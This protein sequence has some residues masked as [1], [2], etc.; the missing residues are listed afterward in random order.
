M[1]HLLL[2][3]STATPI[4]RLLSTPH[5]HRQAWFYHVMLTDGDPPHDQLKMLDWLG[6]GRTGTGKDAFSKTFDNALHLPP[7][8]SNHFVSITSVPAYGSPTSHPTSYHP[9]HPS[10]APRIN[11]VRSSGG[12][13]FDGCLEM[14]A[15]Y[16]ICADDPPA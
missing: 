1:C 16:G 3:L 12:R 9:L 2:S 11:Y 7:F 5:R 15:E 10:Y 8:P 13:V 4:L 14:C 6:M